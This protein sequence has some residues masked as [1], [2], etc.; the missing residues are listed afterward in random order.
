VSV[1]ALDGMLDV[2]FALLDAVSVADS[3]PPA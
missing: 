3:A 2:A 1:A